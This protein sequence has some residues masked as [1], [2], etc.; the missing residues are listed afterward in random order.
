M[1]PSSPSR[2]R[3]PVGA[4]VAVLDR[5][6]HA[7]RQSE[8]GRCPTDCRRR[9]QR[10]GRGAQHHLVATLATRRFAADRGRDGSGDWRDP[11]PGQRA[12]Q[13]GGPTQPGHR[14]RRR[15][16][17]ERQRPRRRTTIGCRPAGRL[18][19]HQ[20]VHGPRRRADHQLGRRA[21]GV[22]QRRPDTRVHGLGGHGQPRRRHLVRR[23]AAARRLDRG[24]PHGGEFD[25]ARLSV[26]ALGRG[27]CLGQQP[28]HAAGRTAWPPT[29]TLV[30]PSPGAS[31]GPCCRTSSSTRVRPPPIRPAPCRP[32]PS[33]SLPRTWPTPRS[34]RP[35][36]H[37]GRATRT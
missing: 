31:P 2:A 7:G 15:G 5:P 26:P 4:A 21:V 25:A 13:P 8:P 27:Q 18:P 9:C 1:S 32:H 36:R 29:A 10:S 19:R 16:R 12:A 14:G 11:G 35:R 37:P 20:H 24:R 34:S 17:P 22:R 33:P 30:R 28:Q 23:G 6:L 3:R